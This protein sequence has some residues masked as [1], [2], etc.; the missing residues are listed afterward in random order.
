MATI[1]LYSEII[2]P[3]LIEG[4]PAEGFL[5]RLDGEIVVVSSMEGLADKT[6]ELAAEICALSPVEGM[7]SATLNLAGEIV[8]TYLMEGA[9][10]FLVTLDG[11]IISVASLEGKMSE[12]FLRRLHGDVISSPVS[13]DSM[14]SSHFSLTGEII[15]IG[16]IEGRLSQQYQLGI[17]AGENFLFSGAP[18]IGGGLAITW[19]TGEAEIPTYWYVIGVNQSTGWEESPHGSLKWGMVKTDKS[20]RAVNYYVS[21]KDSNLVGHI[22]RILVRKLSSA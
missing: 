4:V 20:G 2:V 11:E 13:Q 16:T 8:A 14:L 19:L 9:A 7:A 3:S 5:R 17:A 22:D 15:S 18:K 6:N 21:P 10:G 12:G 1:D